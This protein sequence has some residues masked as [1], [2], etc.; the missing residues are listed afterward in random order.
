MSIQFTLDMYN[1]AHYY[2]M[3][4]T[5]GYDNKIQYDDHIDSDNEWK[6]RTFHD[7]N[8]EL[9]FSIPIDENIGLRINEL[10]SPYTEVACKMNGSVCGGR[11]IDGIEGAPSVYGRYR[12]TLPALRWDANT[13]T[14]SVFQYTLP[15]I[16]VHLC[17][18]ESL[19]NDGKY[20][21]RMEG[22]IQH[23]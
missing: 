3:P 8:T 2:I 22:V 21:V 4:A 20:F 9:L 17:D 19:G 14:D 18:L 16:E 1:L 6:F 10:S 7:I 15:H 12:Q 5:N 13:A 11:S 23:V